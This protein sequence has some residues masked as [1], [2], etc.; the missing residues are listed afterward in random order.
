MREFL[1]A[2]LNDEQ[3]INELAYEKLLELASYSGDFGVDL[4]DIM[5]KIKSTEGRY[6]LPEDHELKP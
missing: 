6:Y 3:G 2:L 5:G 4:N 1:I